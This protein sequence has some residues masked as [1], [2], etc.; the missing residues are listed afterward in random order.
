MCS[1]EVSLPRGL[2]GPPQRNISAVHS[3]RIGD[4]VSPRFEPYIKYL[5]Y[6]SF[7][8]GVKQCNM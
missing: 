6:V 4:K 2:L 3:T 1:I 5:L 8:H 7:E